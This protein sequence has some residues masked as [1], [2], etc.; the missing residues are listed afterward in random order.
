MERS[1]STSGLI[2]GGIVVLIVGLL[3]GVGLWYSAGQRH[4]DAVRN[5]AR[6]PVGCVTTLDFAE[7]G[8]YLL[9]V[10]TRGEIGDV[11]GDC[12]V[13]GAFEWTGT[14]QP[15]TTVTLTD[16][17][18]RDVGFD[19][20]GGVSYDAAGSTG[21]AI[22]G[23]SIDTPGDHLLTV[24]DAPAGFAIAVGRDPNDGVGLLRAGAALAAAAGVIIGGALFVLAAR[25]TSPPPVPGP[26][27]G[28]WMHTP[29]GASPA[30]GP[31]PG[32]RPVTGP[33]TRPPTVPTAP[34][35]TPPVPGQPAGPS[36]P[37]GGPPGGPP[38]APATAAPGR[39]TGAPRGTP[40][41]TGDGERSPWAPPDDS[42]R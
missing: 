36:S 29:P 31:P 21:N 42:V 41:G 6:A 22:E 38:Q 23:F 26:A 39:D 13:P 15:S 12:G 2:A 14:S 1:R 9:F 8:R 35:T 5:L 4:D 37:P 16:P 32:W 7:Q 19:S 40:T 30:G 20:F 17:E 11:V 27:S 18:G 10:E 24:A 3:T 25:R 34:P 28:P 33:P